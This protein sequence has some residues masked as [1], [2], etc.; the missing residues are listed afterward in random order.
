MKQIVFLE[1]NHTLNVLIG[2]DTLEDPYKKNTYKRGIDLEYDIC[3]KDLLIV[4]RY[5]LFIVPANKFT[6]VDDHLRQILNFNDNIA[7][8]YST[9]NFNLNVS[10]FFDH[11]D[12]EY[13]I[14]RIEPLFIEAVNIATNTTRRFTNLQYVFYAC[15]IKLE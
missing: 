13:Q 10:Y 3:N 7:P 15:K 9:E 14:N 11:E 12:E 6:I 1:T 5:K 4:I 2:T 8:L